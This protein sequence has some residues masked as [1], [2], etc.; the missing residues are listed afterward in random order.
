MTYRTDAQDRQVAVLNDE[1]RVGRAA[2]EP[3]ELRQLPPLPL[4]PH[5]AALARVPLTLAMEQVE[6]PWTMPRVELIHAPLRRLQQGRV[7]RQRAGV[8]VREV[9]QQGEMQMWIA[10]GEKTDFELIEERHQPV[11]GF[12]DRRHDDHRPVSRRDAGAQIEPRQRARADLLRHDEVQD[13]DHQ[14]ARGDE[15]D[16]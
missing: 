8:A 3:V 10:V 12:D 6:A 5:P 1:A 13:A 9:G 16:E 15:R 11:F 14:L 7:A 2:Q 4:L